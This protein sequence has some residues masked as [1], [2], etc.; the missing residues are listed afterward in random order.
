MDDVLPAQRLKD[1]TFISTAAWVILIFAFIIL[2]WSGFYYL[3]LQLVAE[4]QAEMFSG[5]DAGPAV[6]FSQDFQRIQEQMSLGIMV[7]GLGSL[8][9]IVTSIAVLKRRNWGRILMTIA[10]VA[11]VATLL[12]F[13]FYV[14]GQ[15]YD[16]MNETML[17]MPGGF[18]DQ[19]H[20]VNRMQKGF[21]LQFLSYGIFVLLICWALLRVII[22]LNR[23]RIRALFS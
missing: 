1:E 7:A 19:G 10:S 12:F 6:E 13:V 8:M 16:K 4:T 2:Y 21:R 23:R 5:V 14:G 9:L 20:I 3:T 11:L 17:G 22:K 18:N 15:W